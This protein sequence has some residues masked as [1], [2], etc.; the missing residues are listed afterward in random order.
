MKE[1][2]TELVI[3]KVSQSNNVSTIDG[4][5]INMYTVAQGKGNKRVS[6]TRHMTEPQADALRKSLGGK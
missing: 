2:S 1:K 6:H 5:R 4:Q 3:T